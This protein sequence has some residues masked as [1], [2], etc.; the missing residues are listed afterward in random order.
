MI[1]IHFWPLVQSKNQYSYLH[2]YSFEESVNDGATLPISF[3][4]RP[5]RLKID[6]EEIDKIFA[7]I[8]DGTTEE[9]QAILSQK[10]GQIPR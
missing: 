3:E 10:A 4:T 1:E 9:D 2:K 8:T 5:V 7:Q 6:K